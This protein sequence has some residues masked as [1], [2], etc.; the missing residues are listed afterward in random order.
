MKAKEQRLQ[1]RD[2]PEL[3]ALLEQM[4][5]QEPDLQWLLT[6]P[7]PTTA[8]PKTLPD[9]EIYRQQVQEAI[10]LGDYLRK[11]K[12]HEVERR[13]SA[14][15]AIADRF[16]ERQHVLA[17]LIIYEVLVTEIIAQY[18]DY[19][20]E[21]IAFTVVLTGCV[22][23]LDTCFADAGQNQELRLRISHVLFALYRFFT[24]SD[25]DLDEDIPGLL[26]ENSTMQERAVIAEW[27]RKAMSDLKEP[28]WGVN[29]ARSHYETFLAKL[30]STY[31]S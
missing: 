17:A 27:V 2:T 22:D 23:G 28:K 14:I 16:A 12:R 30:V 13:L 18:N 3:I 7:L 24:D 20:D 10:V 4:L 5:R 6:T 15:K 1:Q 31:R 26:V 11:Y 25:R 8:P 21:Y 9:P 19:R 29:S